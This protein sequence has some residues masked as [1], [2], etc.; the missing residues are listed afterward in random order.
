MSLHISVLAMAVLAEVAGAVLFYTMKQTSVRAMFSLFSLTFMLVVVFMDLLPDAGVYQQLDLAHLGLFFSGALLILALGAAGKYLGNYAA[1]AGMGFHNLCE[2][3]EVA[4]IA[5][6]SPTVLAG[7]L[8]HK[9]PE[10]MVSFSL[11][12]G[13]KDGKRFFFATLIALLIPLGALV[14]ISE[15]LTQYVTALG[16]GVIVMVVIKSMGVQLT[17]IRKE[18]QVNLM[19]WLSIGVS[20]GAV[21]VVSCL[22]A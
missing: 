18:P 17:M 3:V 9:L 10:G 19:K 2:G 15:A 4:A 16:A 7:F 20:G 22:I 14:P 6:L 21:G 5:S 8:L 12:D 1:V 11:L 13:M